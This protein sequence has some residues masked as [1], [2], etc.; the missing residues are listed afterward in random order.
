MMAL[1]IVR[2][3]T[4]SHTDS[5]PRSVIT[6]ERPMSLASLVR[7]EDW[8]ALEKH[9]AH[10]MGSGAPIDEVLAA[11]DLARETKQVSRILPF[12]REH[13]DLLET[14]ERNADS[15]LV[16]GHTLLA[17]GPPGELS[18]RLFRC[19]KAAWESESWYVAYVAL[20]GF[21][22]SAEDVRKAWRGFHQLMSLGEGSAV[23]HRSGWGPGEVTELERTKLEVRIKFASGRRD[24]FPIKSVIDTCDVLDA[25]DLRALVVKNPDELARMIREEPLEVLTRVLRRYNGR[26][27]QAVLKTAMA[28]LNLEGTAFTSWWRKARKIAEQS[29][30]HEVTGSGAQT[31]IRLLDTVV[32]PSASMKRQLRMSKDLAAAIAR[33]R[34]LLADRKLELA[35]RDAALET[36]EELAEQKDVPTQQRLAAWMLLRMVRGTTPPQL[37]ARLQRAAEQPPPAQGEPPALWEVFAQ[38]PAARDQEACVSVLKEIFGE[39]RW[40]D[41]ACEHLMH[42]PPGMVRSLVEEILAAGRNDVLKQAYSSLLIRPTRNPHLLIVLAEHAEAGRIKGDF[43]PP[44]QR[45]HSLLTLATF[46][47]TGEGADPTRTRAQLKLTQVLT[48]GDKNSLMAR[49]LTDASRKEIRALMPV[50]TKGVDP[51]LDRAFTHVAIARFPT[52]YRDDNRPFWEEENVIWTTQKGLDRRE[53]ELRELREVK[54]PANSEA[55][56]KAASYGDLSENSEWESAMEDQRTLTSR[57]MEIEE[58]VRR[59]RLIEHAA[60]PEGIVTPGTRVT[61]RDPSNVVHKVDIVGPWD[62]TASN[63]IS[64]RSPV[65]QG[66]LGA[67]MGETATLRLPTGVIEVKI[68]KVELVPLG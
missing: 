30:G 23:F 57:A 4:T 17:G 55:I 66:L 1:A 26:T 65:G 48:V 7:A 37:A 6:I 49:L 47:F 56:G 8:T 5:V 58:E 36:L 62:T 60:I 40:L 64:Y 53:E 15:A 12:V 29:N 42:G 32:D 2:A 51:A 28:Q 39:E 21:K 11:I 52:I 44:V 63:A 46:L 19:S 50:L 34:D 68:E 43:P 13:A 33:V 31:Q 14:A 24:W 38:L 27:T 10:L 9:W 16:L 18:L 35:V 41:H 22:E 3:S 67:R 25:D 61:Y 20:S 54:I 59:A 45:L